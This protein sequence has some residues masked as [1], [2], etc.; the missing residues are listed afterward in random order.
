MA[1]TVNQ[2]ISGAYY[3]SG[4]VSREFETVSGSQVADGLGFLND[5][6]GEKVVDEG[7]VPYESTFSITGVIGQEE[8]VVP[9][10]IKIDTITF[11]KDNVRYAMQEQKRNQYLGSSRVESITSLPNTYFWEKELGGVR[12]Y[13][14]FQPDEAY[15]FTVHGIS[16]LS[17]VSLGQDLELTLD[18]FYITYLRYALADRICA[19]FEYDTPANVKR[20]LSKYEAWINKKSRVLDLRMTKQ[21]TLK[22]SR[23]GINYGDVNLGRGWST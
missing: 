6:L 14:Y 9:D 20:Q 17:S 12:L 8:Y 22:R 13:V 7:M 4:V 5:I 19:E 2:L 23:Q 11:I 15:P 18:R 16:R 1:Y 21:S 3:A 10:L